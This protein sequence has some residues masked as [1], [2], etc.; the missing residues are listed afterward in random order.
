MPTSRTGPEDLEIRDESDAETVAP[1]SG[2]HDRDPRSHPRRPAGDEG[3]CRQAFGFTLS[4]EEAERERPMMDLGR[5]RV[6]VDGG[7][8]VGGAGSWDLG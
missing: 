5:F 2:N 6:A 3:R 7:A 1:R 8:V 4:A